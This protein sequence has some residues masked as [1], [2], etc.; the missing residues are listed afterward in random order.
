[1]YFYTVAARALVAP[2]CPF[3]PVTL[4]FSLSPFPSG[5]SSCSRLSR[6]LHS[7]SASRTF[8]PFSCVY[9]VIGCEMKSNENPFRRVHSRSTVG[10]VAQ[11]RPRL[12]PPYLSLLSLSLSLSFSPLHCPCPL[13]RSRYL[14]GCAFPPGSPCSALP[15]RPGT[16]DGRPVCI[17]IAGECTTS[18]RGWGRGGTRG[19][20]EV[21]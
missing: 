5:L 11:P 1:V 18:G 16:G 7:V 2:R 9:Q 14:H 21:A 12:A 13:F 15:A 4:P 10:R 19:D 20:E 6:F 8:P 3:V 17:A